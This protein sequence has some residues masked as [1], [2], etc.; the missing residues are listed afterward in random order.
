MGTQLACDLR[1]T[2]NLNAVSSRSR[3]V[4]NCVLSFQSEVKQ[5][6]LSF[7]LCLFSYHLYVLRS[8]K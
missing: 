4:V 5:S 6:F 8:Q 2:P 7:E 3:P 1:G